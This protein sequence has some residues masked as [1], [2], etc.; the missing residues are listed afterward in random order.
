MVQDEVATFGRVKLSLCSLFVLY[1]VVALVL[2]ALFPKVWTKSRT[3]ERFH[4]LETAGSLF[5]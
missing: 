2:A 3:T 5:S 1:G 4:S